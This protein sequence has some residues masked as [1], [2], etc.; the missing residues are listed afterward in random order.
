MCLAGGVPR[1]LTEQPKEQ[2]TVE[3]TQQSPNRRLPI[4]QIGHHHA[5][6]VK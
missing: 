1:Q 6:E 5:Q 4:L 2:E 3:A